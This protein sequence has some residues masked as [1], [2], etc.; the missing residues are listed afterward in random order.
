[1]RKFF[2]VLLAIFPLVLLRGDNENVRVIL[3]S[4][5]QHNANELQNSAYQIELRKLQLEEKRLYLSSLQGSRITE[6]KAREASEW[7][8]RN[9][10]D[11]PQGK[12]AKHT[13]EDLTLLVETIMALQKS[14]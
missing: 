3:D 14:N 6:A 11:Y 9:L 1:M 7:I 2:I 5:Q 10:K 8:L 13:D 12:K 4:I